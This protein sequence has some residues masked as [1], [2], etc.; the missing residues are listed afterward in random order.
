FD[1]EELLH[2][3][4]VDPE[5]SDDLVDNEQRA[6]FAGEIAEAGEKAGFREDH[7]HVGGYGF[8][9]DGGD[10]ISAL[11]E[12]VLNSPEVVVRGVHGKAGESVGNAG[13][14]GDA[15]SRQT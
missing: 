8:D 6:V 14:L 7:A 2:R 3:A 4:V 13:A 5:T 1:A 11:G 15:E 9:D 12:Q 10:V